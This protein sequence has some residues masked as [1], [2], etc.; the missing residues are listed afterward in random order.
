MMCGMSVD[1]R[2]WNIVAGVCVAAGCGSR[3]I[4]AEADGTADSTVGDTETG[5]E[6]QTSA[7]C[8]YYYQCYSGVCEYAPHHDGHIDHTDE[9]WYGDCYSDYDCSA[10]ALCEFNYCN[11][12]WTPSTCPDIEPVQIVPVP[13]VALALAFVDAD[14]DGA[15]ELAIATANDIVLFESGDGVPTISPRNIGSGFVDA[16][17]SGE[18]DV[19]VGE[20]LVLLVDDQLY[21]HLSIGG[22]SF[23]V[24][25]EHSPGWPMSTGMAVGLFDPSPLA[26]LLLWGESGAM[27]QL[28]GQ[29]G[30]VLLDQPVHAASA[31]SVSDP[32]SGYVAQTG[33]TL[34]F[35]APDLSGIASADL[36]GNEP[37]ALTSL[38]DLGDGYDLSSSQ[39]N[40]LG[41]EWSLLTEWGPATGNMGMQWGV[42]GR[43]RQMIAGDFGGDARADVALA[44]SNGGVERVAIQHNVH[45]QGCISEY[46]V[47]GVIREI[48]AGDHDGD[49]DLELGVRLSTGEIWL[50]DGE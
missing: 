9:Y 43:V 45:S 42:T 27:V 6:C 21:D 38:T 14:A 25:M 50:I 40:G 1:P 4:S 15:D 17:A 19:N 22:G 32:V 2:A 10:F 49:G 18:L 30:G 44:G 24:A 16:M 26:D 5:P 23:D 37:I 35:F 3:T 11:S 28:D 36:R 47:E 41:S 39:M 31:R 33:L 46:T 29:P 48:A 20:D 13:D 12:L 34:W 8:P 7:D